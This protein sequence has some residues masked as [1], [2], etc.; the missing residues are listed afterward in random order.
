[1]EILSPRP[2]TDEPVAKNIGAALPVEIRP[3]QPVG[4]GELFLRFVVIVLGIGIGAVVA[5]FIGL[6]TGGIPFNC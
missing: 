3:R 6:A 5:L 4:G 2:P 1:M